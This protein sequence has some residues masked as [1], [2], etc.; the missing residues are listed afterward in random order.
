MP[1][2]I[3]TIKSN[4]IASFK[5]LLVFIISLIFI[6]CAMQS[7]PSG[8]PPDK[9]PPEIISVYPNADS[10]HVGIYLNKIIL[11]FS[12]RMNE[13]TLPNNLFISPLLKY[14]L[15]WT[16]TTELTIQVDDTLKK[17][18]TYVVTIGSGAQD[19]HNNK[20][21]QSFQFAFS[22]GSKIDHGKIAG[23]VFGLKNK[24]TINMFAYAVNDT[25]IMD[26]DIRKPDYISQSGIDGL[27]KFDYLKAGT[28]RIF[29]VQDQ[30]NNFLIDRNFEKV[31]I[32]YRD[33]MI[34]SS[35]Q[36]YEGLSFLLSKGDTIHPYVISAKAMNEHYIRVRLNKEV[37]TPEINK[38]KVLDSLANNV[39]KL[40]GVS[41]NREEPFFM[42]LYTDSLNEDSFYKVTI[43]SLN[44]SV[45][46]SASV[47]ETRK[48]PG[49]NRPDTVSLALLKF[50]PKDSTLDVHPKSKVH[51]E[52]SRPIN[53]PTMQESFKLHINSGQIINGQWD[54]RNLYEADFIP[55]NEFLPDSFYIASLSLNSIRDLWGATLGDSMLQHH[56][57][58][59]SLRQLGEISGDV[60]IKQ[61]Q[62]PVFINF[63]ELKKK[64]NIYTLRIPEPGKFFKPYLPGGKYLLDSFLDIDENGT[65]SYGEINPFIYA[66]PFI[67]INDT[68]DVRNRW[69][70]SG[71]NVKIPYG[72]RSHE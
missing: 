64:K 4:I 35:I 41:K 68:I 43:S 11:T 47:Q 52:F 69:E 53:W 27:Y 31:G 15:K 56:F 72:Q 14:E 18:Q 55:D 62:A 42:E 54:L 30:N 8:G 70:T 60:S 40:F 28:Y 65:Y 21:K 7:L 34:D 26:L 9:T 71:V 23:R 6:K 51:I 5:V 48:F 50:L 3:I 37:V 67:F 57:K 63:K 49:S 46:N 12:E 16:G 38:I 33:V 1:L 58:I 25:V 66:E 24:E 2:K 10:I 22:S 32:P 61:Q 45:G 29:A 36:H 17:D 19:G 20:L 13:G 44:D 39:I 59:I